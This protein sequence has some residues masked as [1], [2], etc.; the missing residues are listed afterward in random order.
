MR[1]KA[2]QII[3]NAKIFT[4][5]KNT[6]QATALVVKDGKFIYV[7]DE[8]GLSAYEGEVTDLGGKFIMPG[9]IDSHVHVTTSI[10]FAYMDPGEYVVCASKKEAL[11]FMAAS[12]KSNPGL[13][14][15]RF[16]LERKYL[17]GEDIVK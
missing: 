12:I 4:A 5:N 10:G 9:I 1:M 16:I 3:R 17:N 7:G 6:L 11:D 14:R 13:K 8:A 2:D 15:H